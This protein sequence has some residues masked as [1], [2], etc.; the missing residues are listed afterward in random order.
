MHESLFSS[1]SN[2]VNRLG[3]HTGCTGRVYINTTHTV[4]PNDENRPTI[5]TDPIQG[6]AHCMDVLWINNLTHF[7][8]KSSNGNLVLTIITIL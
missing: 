7:P 6:P 8:Y 2:Q 4:E 1:V 3:Q 5:D